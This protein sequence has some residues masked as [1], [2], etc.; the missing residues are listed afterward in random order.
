[1]MLK[2]SFGLCQECAAIE[3]AVNAVLQTG[4]RTPD[5]KESDTKQV[6]GT[7]QMGELICRQIQE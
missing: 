2:Y 7:A 5:I 6:V 1:M 4:A 3:N